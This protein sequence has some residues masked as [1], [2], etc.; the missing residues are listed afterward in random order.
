VEQRKKP[1]K[2]GRPKL[3]KGEA[4]GRIV[5]VRFTADELKSMEREARAHGQV[6]SAWVRIAVAME[7]KEHYNGYL[8]ELASRKSNAGGFETFGWIT[9]Q[10]V[11]AKP[12]PVVSPGGHSAKGAALEYGIA[13]CKE[14]IDLGRSGG[15]IRANT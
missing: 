4:K 7:V 10:E 3:P 13:W 2:V 12:I 1:R 14:K 15:T 9:K 5:P 6:L 11:G 8:V